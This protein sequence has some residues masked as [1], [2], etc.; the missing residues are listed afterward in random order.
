[1]KRF[2]Q[3]LLVGGFCCHVKLLIETSTLKIEE[4]NKMK[5]KQNGF[6]LNY[7]S[8]LLVAVG[9][10]LGTFL[11]GQELSNNGKLTKDKKTIQR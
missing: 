11:K 10:M 9:L 1:L 8:M 2:A 7:I 3:D 5:S 6:T 4:L